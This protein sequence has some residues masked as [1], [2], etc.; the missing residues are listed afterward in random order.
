MTVTA[1]FQKT[2]TKT[3]ERGKNPKKTKC[4]GSI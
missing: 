4:A 3:G 2:E 1:F